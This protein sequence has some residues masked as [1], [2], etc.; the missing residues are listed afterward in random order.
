MYNYIPKRQSINPQRFNSELM[1]RIRARQPLVFIDSY[2]EES[3]DSYILRSVRDAQ[4]AGV[5]VRENRIFE[6]VQGVGLLDFNSKVIV[7]NQND[8]NCS[9]KHY[10][11]E[12][13]YQNNDILVI[14]G[15]PSF[16]DCEP[17]RIDWLRMI[18]G[19]DMNDAGGRCDD[20]GFPR[21]GA[22]RYLIVTGFNLRI[23]SPLIPYS[24]KLTV[25][26]PATQEEV[27][28][29]VKDAIEEL[30][31]R[32]GKAY[33]FGETRENFICESAR[34]LQGFNRYEIHQILSYALQPPTSKLHIGIANHRIAKAKRE[35]VERTACLKLVDVRGGSTKNNN[36]EPCHFGGL[37]AILEHLRRV[38]KLFSIREDDLDVLDGFGTKGILLVG[39]PGCGKSMAA[40]AAGAILDLPVIQLDVGRLLGKYV[41][42]SEANL[43]MALDV[44]DRAA[45]CVMYI[46]EL[47]KAFSGLESS[48]GTAL[49]LFGS[50]LTWLQEKRSS[51][52]VIAT[53]NNVDKIPDEFK[54]RGRFDEIF[55]IMLPDQEERESIFRYHLDRL[56]EANTFSFLKQDILAPLCQRLANEC[57]VK[58]DYGFS[59]ADIAHAVYGAATEMLILDD[60]SGVSNESRFEKHLLAEISEAKKNKTTQMGIMMSRKVK[61]E[62]GRDTNAYDLAVERLTKGGYRPAK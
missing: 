51:V 45:P 24:V 31:E 10:L 54:R 5:D 58:D 16:F 48:D 29:I 44:A 3:I 21:E 28:G 46:D 1:F 6:F 57:R 25:P 33:P 7:P 19:N 27:K 50:F 20:D 37:N 18:V 12:T 59:G 43:R 22:F 8:A 40:K 41:G 2:D 34:R 39:M 49:R 17:E 35:M 60:D 62:Y 15:G 23:P 30:E 61:D 55:S 26:I 42:E 36:D 11:F 9:L 13:E 52:Y 32:H 53:A 14:R 38:K 56:R 4:S 47:E